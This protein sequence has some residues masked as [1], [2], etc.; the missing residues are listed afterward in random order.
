MVEE[1]LAPP[2]RFSQDIGM[3]ALRG[4]LTAGHFSSSHDF[5]FGG[6]AVDFGWCPKTLADYRDWYGGA[7]AIAT[8][9]ALSDSPQRISARGTIA[10]R[11][12]SL[13]RHGCVSDELE[14]AVLAIGTQEH[15]PAGWLAVRK[16]IG[17]DRKRMTAELLARLER[18]KERLAPSGLRER[19][20]SKDAAV[21]RPNLPA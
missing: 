15:W 12:R 8:R 14:G 6:H 13:W 21:M 9:L 1:L 19:L 3:I 7:L 17:S 5:S 20:R 4:M 16:T 2:D 11:F 18:M 10:E